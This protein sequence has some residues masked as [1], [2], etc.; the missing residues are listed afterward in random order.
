MAWLSLK[1]FPDCQER[2][3]N[4]QY[5]YGFLFQYNAPA[6]LHTKYLQVEYSKDMDNKD[7]LENKQLWQQVAT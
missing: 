1:F 3:L 7:K 2:A 5:A 4:Q 6:S